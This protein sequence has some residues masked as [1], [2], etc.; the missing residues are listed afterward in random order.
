MGSSKVTLRTSPQKLYDV[1]TGALAPLGTR[2]VL[3]DSREFVYAKAGAVALAAGKLCQAPTTIGANHQALT[4]VA[5]S[6]TVAANVGDRQIQVT[7]GATLASDSQYADGWI[8]VQD[9]TEGGPIYKVIGHA[10]VASAG[11]LTAKLADPLWESYT[12]TSSRWTL[13]SNPW[14]GVLVAPTT[15]VGPIVGVP[16]RDIPIANF[17]W[18]Q[19]KGM[20]S[21]LT[22][23][24]AV[25]I[26]SPVVPS[27]TVAGAI[28]ISAAYVVTSLAVGRCQ[29]V[30]ASTAFSTINLDLSS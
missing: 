16:I 1:S 6:G 30:A 19:V 3:N 20:A 17:G 25:V 21:I 18:L 24:T 12:T 15:L 13:V 29:I 9:A 23:A 27:L 7:L 22:D 8:Q 14:N 11:V 26:G 10:A 28:G 5:V 2:L 4:P